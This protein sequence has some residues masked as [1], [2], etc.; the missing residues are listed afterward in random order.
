MEFERAIFLIHERFMQSRSTKK[1]LVFF[2]WISL[3]VSVLSFLH[4][5][6]YHKIYVNKSQILQTA[7]E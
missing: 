1:I 7:I 3:A 4:F 6:A 5:Y 2:K